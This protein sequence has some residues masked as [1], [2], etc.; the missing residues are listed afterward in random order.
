M[1]RTMVCVFCAM[2]VV[3]A[4]TAG[5]VAAAEEKAVDATIVKVDGDKITLKVGDK[6]QTVDVDK[7]KVKLLRGTDKLKASD[8]KAG[9]K[10]K[11]NQ[12][13]EGKILVIRPGKA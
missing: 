3:F 4:L 12:G 2:A 11:V 8:F 1:L 7:D 10:V 6:E 13:K 5:N 9:D